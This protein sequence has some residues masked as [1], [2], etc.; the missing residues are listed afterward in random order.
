VSQQLPSRPSLAHL[1]KQ[2]KTLLDQL[3]RTNPD[4]TLVAAQHALARDYGFDSWPQL[5]RHV[6]LLARVPGTVTFDR[7][8][9]NARKALFFS[10]YEASQ[11]GSATIEPEHVL[12]GLIRVGEGVPGNAFERSGLSLQPARTALVTSAAEPIPSS[13]MIPVSD[14]VRPVFRVA[15]E[16]ADR[17]HHHG[18]GLVHLLLG[19]LR[20]RDSVAAGWLGT[21]GVRAADIRAHITSW[22]DENPKA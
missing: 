4:C 22:L 12:L 17:L 13:T 21:R 6:E 18:I 20:A 2:A 3:R 11:A 15:A 14:R 5:K 1:K 16:E 7:Y 9:S 8:T 19:V 10:R